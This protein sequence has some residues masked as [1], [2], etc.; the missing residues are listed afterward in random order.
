MMG[1]SCDMRSTCSKLGAGPDEVL[2]GDGVAL[3][4]CLNDRVGKSFH[5][6]IAQVAGSAR[7]VGVA[8][9]GARLGWTSESAR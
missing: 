8:A 1:F 2:P 4:D 6:L 3:Q 5:S 7:A 9:T